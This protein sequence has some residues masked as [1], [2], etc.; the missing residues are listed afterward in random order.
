MEKKFQTEGRDEIRHKSEER[1]FN[2]FYID[3]IAGGWSQTSLIKDRLNVVFRGE[4]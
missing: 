2:L 1:F 4:M 3:V